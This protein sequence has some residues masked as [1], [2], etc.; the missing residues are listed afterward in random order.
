MSQEIITLPS[1]SRFGS[2][3]C[4][5][6]KADAAYFLVDT[7]WSS[8]RAA[9][10]K[11]LEN[12]GCQPGNLNLILVTHGDFDHTGNCAYLRERYRTKIAMHRGDS[13]LVEQGDMFI[14]RKINPLM[15]GII[16]IGASLFGLSK[17]DRFK[18]D[19]FIEDGQDL[20]EYG[21]DAKV[22]LVP[23]HSKGSIAILT[24]SSDPAS[25]SW[26]ALFCGDLLVNSSQ[27]AKNSLVD[28]AAA[29]DASV[30]RVK[31]L[32]PVTVYPGHGKPFPVELLPL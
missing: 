1:K 5:L 2:V 28:D 14:N 20:A 22:L 6:I 8:Q 17:F 30:E 23:G 4:Y 12:S 31:Q 25:G 9:L 11:E 3:N 13:V 16:K 10:E 19:I 32:K 21:L 7:G 26:Q 29:L 24:P 15:R 27:P 18:A